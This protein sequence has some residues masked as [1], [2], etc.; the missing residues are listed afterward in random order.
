MILPMLV[1]VHGRPG[2][3]NEDMLERWEQTVAAMVQGDAT[4]LIHTA[5]AQL[6]LMESWFASL[7]DERQ[8]F[9]SLKLPRHQLDICL[10]RH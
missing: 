10:Q 4:D 1:V 2:F 3:N 7:P 6:Q 5:K 8:I 9:V